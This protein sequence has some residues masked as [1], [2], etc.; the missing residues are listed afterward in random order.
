MS[1]LV[2]LGFDTEQQALD[3]LKSLRRLESDGRISFEDTAVVSHGLD[4]KFQVKNEASSTTETGA[5]VGAILGGFVTFIFPVAGI[6]I[7]ALAGAG[8]GS[9]MGR[10]VSGDFV[11]DVK[12]ELPPGKSALFLLVK[13]ADVDAALGVLRNFK[14]DVI[15]TT[16]DPDAEEAIRNALK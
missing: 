2:V 1:Q 12:E 15:Q 13:G 16:L 10:G 7:G 6:A 5:V 9:L 11:K 14:G 4:G 3:A 8:V